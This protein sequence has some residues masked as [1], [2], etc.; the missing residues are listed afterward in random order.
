MRDDDAV[1]DGEGVDGEAG[2][3][4]RPALHGVAQGVIQDEVGAAG[5]PELL[6]LAVPL[7]QAFLREGNQAK[8]VF[9]IR[10]EESPLGRYHSMEL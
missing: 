2:Q 10:V 7:V 8:I 9:S 3:L 1:V 4:P 6:A 5:D